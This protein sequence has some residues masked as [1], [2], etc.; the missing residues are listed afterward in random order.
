MQFKEGVSTEADIINKLGRPS[1]VT[2]NGDLKMI[3][4]YGSQYQAKAAS[5]IP[6]I[7]AFVGGS[8]IAVTHVAYQIGQGGILKKI[9]YSSSGTGT[10]RGSTPAEMANTEPSAVK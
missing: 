7:G 1:S 6:I 3:S 4:Y 2:L 5:F 10:R 8:D 9:I